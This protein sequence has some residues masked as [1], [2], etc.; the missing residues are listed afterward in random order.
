MRGGESVASELALST[1]SHQHNM[2]LLRLDVNAPHVS[3]LSPSLPPSQRP[4]V[5]TTLKF[6]PMHMHMH[7]GVDIQVGPHHWSSAW[8]CLCHWA[9]C[10]CTP[11]Q[12][13]PDRQDEA[14][15]RGKNN[16][17]FLCWWWEGFCESNGW[18]FGR[19]SVLWA[20]LTQGRCDL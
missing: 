10:G 14:H 20:L 18:G 19:L 17:V 11:A 15:G 7:T 13:R 1:H 6:T 5:T 16:G 3:S 2:M 8:L 12:G 9:V 4:C